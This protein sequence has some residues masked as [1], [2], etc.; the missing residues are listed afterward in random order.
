RTVALTLT[1]GSKH[2]VV[3]IYD[4]I[5][6]RS[7]L[8][9]DNTFYAAA[10][11]LSGATLGAYPTG[12]NV[13]IGGFNV[14]RLSVHSIIDNWVIYGDIWTQ[15]DVSKDYNNSTFTETDLPALAWCEMDTKCLK[16]N[17]VNSL[18]DG[19]MEAVGISAWTVVTA[20]VSK[21]T[22][23]P[24][25]GIQVL[26][27][28]SLG[29]ST[30][31][32]KQSIL[33]V[34]R[35]YRVC[36]FARSVFGIATPEITEDPYNKLWTGTT[37]TDWQ[38]FEIEFTATGTGLRFYGNTSTTIDLGSE[39]DSISVELMEVS[40]L[41]KGTLGDIIVGDGAG[42]KEPTFNG[43]CYEFD[44]VTD[45]I[46]QL[47]STNDIKSF[48]FLASTPADSNFRRLAQKGTHQ[49]SPLMWSDNTFQ[50]Y[51]GGSLI[52]SGITVSAGIHLFSGTYD[53]TNLTLYV[54]GVQG[55]SG[56]VNASTGTD[57]I[58]FGQTTGAGQIWKGCIYDFVATTKE[59]SLRQHREIYQKLLNK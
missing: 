32:V 11:T 46:L 38:Y 40:T 55:S 16:E 57:N 9:I 50:M 2:R 35:R 25:S 17:G 23:N 30:P 44:G 24:Q 42:N 51:Y 33:T 12:T 5:T 47:E 28:I 13:M 21:E 43:N 39:F 29:G 6:G 58:V 37:S 7:D 54:D 8:Y 31:Y 15:E 45:E 10:T 19:D 4:P 41:N 36:G 18:N 3:L 34:G 27:I 1:S 26:R 49:F 48:A 14:N 52:N 56:V 20:S 22:T 53:G 59:W